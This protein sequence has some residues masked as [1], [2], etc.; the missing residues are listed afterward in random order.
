M[1]TL[2]IAAIGTLAV[3]FAAPAFADDS[4]ADNGQ[5]SCA[6]ASATAFAQC[7]IDSAAQGSDV[8]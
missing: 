3:L 1:R 4:I 5:L 6:E 8:E 7:V 2:L